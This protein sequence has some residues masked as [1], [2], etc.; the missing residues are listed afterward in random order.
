VSLSAE[1]TLDRHWS[2]ISQVSAVRNDSNLAPSDFRR[3]QAQLALRYR[4]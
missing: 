3:G 2:L 4:F 1:R